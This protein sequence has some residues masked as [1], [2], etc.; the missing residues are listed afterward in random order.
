MRARFFLQK[1]RCFICVDTRPLHTSFVFFRQ[2]NGEILSAPKC[3]Q[4]LNDLITFP[5]F[6]VQSDP[7]ELTA[8][9]IV[10]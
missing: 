10:M 1:D 7:A 2:H 6:G 4:G 3:P 5:L 8:F 9:L